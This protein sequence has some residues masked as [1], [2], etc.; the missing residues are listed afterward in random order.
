[1]KVL[2]D[3]D[4]LSGS[5]LSGNIDDLVIEG[6][7]VRFLNN[8]MTV[9]VGASAKGFAC[10]KIAERLKEEGCKAFVLSMGGNVVTCGTNNGKP[11]KVG[12]QSSSGNSLLTVLESSDEAIVTSGGYNRFVEID[13]KTYHHIIDPDTLYPCDKM[14]SVT[15]VASSSAYADV[16]STYFFQ[17]DTDR[18]LETAEKLGVMIIIEDNSG[19]ILY[20]KGFAN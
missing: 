1:M 16:L 5:A 13:G 4:K 17:L 10:Q 12:V 20:S 7:T 19:N 14:K 3:A 18:A 9:D 2:P 6:N 8:S 11:W 15:V